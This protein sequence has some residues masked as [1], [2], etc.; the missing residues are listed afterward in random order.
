MEFQKFSFVVMEADL[1]LEFCH[2]KQ[3]LLKSISDIFIVIFDTIKCTVEINGCKL[4]DL[5]IKQSFDFNR[6]NMFWRFTR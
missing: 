4:L 1:P 6:M 2:Q 3:P 5:Q